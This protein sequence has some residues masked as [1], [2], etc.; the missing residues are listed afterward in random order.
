[1]YNREDG[2]S[3][4]LLLKLF[5]RDVFVCMYFSIINLISLHKKYHQRSQI[6]RIKYKRWEDGTTLLDIEG[7]M[8]RY[9]S[10]QKLSLKLAYLKMQFY[11]FFGF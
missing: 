9:C 3:A 2:R 8:L 6:E 5:G 1:M 10:F 11:C 7:A 4:V